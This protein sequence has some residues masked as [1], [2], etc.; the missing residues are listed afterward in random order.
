[1][2]G[3]WQLEN[4]SLMLD[5]YFNKF[6]V[7]RKIYYVLINFVTK[8]SE[9]FAIYRSGNCQNLKCTKTMILAVRFIK[10][11]KGKAQFSIFLEKPNTID[12]FWQLRA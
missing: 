6:D 12:R 11:S 4:F 2:S 1:M 9:I 5:I 3:L 7:L 8:N 10:A